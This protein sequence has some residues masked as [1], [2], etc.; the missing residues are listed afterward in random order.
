MYWLFNIV[1][2]MKFNLI[3]IR[4]CKHF[5]Q[6]S[7][8]FFIQKSNV[9]SFSTFSFFFLKPY[10]NM[11]D[12]FYSCEQNYNFS[13]HFYHN[14]TEMEIHLLLKFFTNGIKLC[15]CVY[16]YI[17]NRRFIYFLYSFAIKWL[18]ATC[19]GHKV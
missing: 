2:D 1:Y 14:I 19:E 17:Y 3:V 9:Y 7:Y 12:N 8:S 16:L 18:A 4:P 11:F 13:P 15:V 5:L 6:S 10:Y